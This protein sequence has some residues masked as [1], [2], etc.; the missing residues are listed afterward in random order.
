M[1]TNIVQNVGGRELTIPAAYG[2]GAFADQAK[3]VI[4]DEQSAICEAF[5]SNTAELSFVFVPDNM[6]DRVLDG[7][8]RVLSRV[9]AEAAANP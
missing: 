7:K 1:A 4:N 5:E 2:G 3:L 6:K 9:E 8:I